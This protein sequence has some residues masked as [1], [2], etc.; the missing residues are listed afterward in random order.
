MLSFKGADLAAGVVALA[1]GVLDTALLETDERLAR[2]CE[3]SATV[4][5]MTDDSVAFFLLCLVLSEFLAVGCA[6]ALLPLER[7][8]ETECDEDADDDDDDDDE[9]EEEE[10]SSSL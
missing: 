6:S 3:V 9:E 5:A 8:F 1:L 2:V 7:A 10:A 4:A